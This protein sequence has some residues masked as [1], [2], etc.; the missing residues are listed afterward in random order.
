[1]AAE[2]RA[3][4]PSTRTA[5]SMQTRDAADVRA[6]LTPKEFEI[7]ALMGRGMLSKEIAATLDISSHTVQAHRKT[8]AVK[9][10]TTGNEL[11]QQ[12]VRHHEKNL[13]TAR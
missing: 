12:A 6:I 10:G 11:L 8:I 9:L 13:E 4:I 1:L 2:I 5:A 3:L 7:F